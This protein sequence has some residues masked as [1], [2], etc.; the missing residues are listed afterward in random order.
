MKE[1]VV[2]EIAVPGDIESKP[3]ELRDQ[4]IPIGH[5]IEDPGVALSVVGVKHRTEAY[6]E[7]LVIPLDDN[8]APTAI[9]KRR[10]RF[11]ISNKHPNKPREQ[12]GRVSDIV[13]DDLRLM[14][15]NLERDDNGAKLNGRERKGHVGQCRAAT[16][17]RQGLFDREP[18]T[19][20]DF[21]LPAAAV[22][23]VDGGG[24]QVV[25]CDPKAGHGPLFIAV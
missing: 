17:R 24:A 16:E 8:V 4:G 25:G 1:E 2:S 6:Q 20:S 7:G 9:R 13:H 12:Q 5:A 14:L 15:T 21:A 18:T 19:I 3:A 22:G 23:R 11:A 10:V